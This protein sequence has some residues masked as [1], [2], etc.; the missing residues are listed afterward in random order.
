MRNFEPFIQQHLNVFLQQWDAMAATG[1]KADGFSN[2]E[3]RVW[4]K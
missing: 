3:A 2:V 1:A 4:L